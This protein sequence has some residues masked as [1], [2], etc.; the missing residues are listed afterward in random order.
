MQLWDTTGRERYI[1]ITR[2]YYRGSAGFL[3]IF[4]LT[5]RKSFN[6]V[7]QWINEAQKFAPANLPIILVGNKSDLIA[8]RQVTFEQAT[9]LAKQL[10]LPYMETSALSSSNVEQVFISLATGILHKKTLQS[11]DTSS[12]EI[13]PRTSQ[14]MCHTCAPKRMVAITSCHGCALNFCH[15]HFDEHRE[16]LAHDFD[17]VINQHDGILHSFQANMYHSLNPLDNDNA[18]ALLKQIDEW[19][20]KAIE[21]CYRVADNA[22][23][24]VEKLLKKIKTNDH[25]KKRVDELSKELKEQQGLENFVETDLKKWKK[26]LEELEKDISQFPE[27]S[28]NVTIEMQMINWENMIRISY[29]SN[30]EET[31]DNQLASMNTR[32]A[33]LYKAL[34]FKT[35]LYSCHLDKTIDGPFSR[36]TSFLTKNKKKDTISEE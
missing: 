9:A 8:Q 3:V 32:D 27:M 16:K 6:N 14:T 19:Q 34:L 23:A 4:D 21:A 24:K 22:R 12:S 31:I 35:L 2:A 29:I 26:Q 7:G 11:I 10:N 33:S 30:P 15:K 36:L 28:R 25:I 1:A 18:Q 17:N 13:I 20:A 5:N